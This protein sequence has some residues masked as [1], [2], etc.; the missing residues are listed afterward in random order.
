ME[1]KGT[2]TMNNFR[3]I[4][5]TGSTGFLG[6]KLLNQIAGAMTLGR[7]VRQDAGKLERWLRDMKPEAIVHCAGLA[8][9]RRSMREPAE[10]FKANAVDT[11]T[12]L[13]ALE[14]KG[15]LLVY[16][17]TD[18]VFGDQEDCGL[19]TAYKPGN[20]YD[21]SKVAA[22]VAVRD[23]ATRNPCVM[24]RFPNFYGAGDW[25][26]ERLLPAIVDAIRRKDEVFEVRTNLEAS[27]QY[28]YI[29]DAVRCIERCLN[30]PGAAGVHHF[31][32]TIVKS[33]REVVTD[34]CETLGYQMQLRCLNLGGEASKLS[35]A[36][37]S[38]FNVPLT[39]WKKSL[40]CFKDA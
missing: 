16:V 36:Y 4:G 31:G 28:I 40:D 15:V 21:A 10:A 35:L 22:E 11:M 18:K 29:E 7:E 5:V 23:F 37:Q 38:P 13:A 32:T 33:V 27:R 25:H 14:G 39:D 20:S 9:V 8:D 19:D 6:G 17:A 34:L 1:W 12:L 2:E 3:I 24:A 26:H 30:N